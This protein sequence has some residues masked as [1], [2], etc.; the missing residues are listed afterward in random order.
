M[1]INYHEFVGRIETVCGGLRGAKPVLIPSA[2]V[3]ILNLDWLR[4]EFF[5]VWIKYKFAYAAQQNK[6]LENN[7][8]RGICDEIAGRC[9]TLLIEASRKEMGDDPTAGAVAEINLMIPAGYSLNHVPGYGGHRTLLL[10]VTTD[11]KDWFPL[12]FEQQLTYENY[13]DTSLDDA[14]SNNVVLYDFWL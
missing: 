5:P 2:E 9:K 4:N 3:N 10:G 13:Q 8:K 6:P 12:F 7:V 14:V 11:N 1:K